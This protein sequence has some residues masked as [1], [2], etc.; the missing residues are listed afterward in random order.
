MK[1][2]G[3]GVLL[4]MAGLAE[5]ALRIHLFM[6]WGLLMSLVLLVL[7]SAAKEKKWLHITTGVFVLTFAI[8]FAPWGSLLYEL[9]AE[10]LEDPDVVDFVH[11]FRV[12]AMAW[13]VTWFSAAVSGFGFWYRKRNTP[14][15]IW[16]PD[17]IQKG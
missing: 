9:S 15:I 4:S 16:K 10:D 12:L 6:A 2:V 3:E 14:D 1:L 17:P 5:A 8:M 13:N 7:A 11:H